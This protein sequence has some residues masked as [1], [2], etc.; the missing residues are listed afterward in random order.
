MATCHGPLLLRTLRRSSAAAAATPAGKKGKSSKAS[1]KAAAAAA[2][3][4]S[5]NPAAAAAAQQVADLARLDEQL[6]LAAFQ[7]AAD[8]FAGLVSKH[9]VKLRLLAALAGLWGLAGPAAV[10]EQYEELAKPHMHVG[11]SELQVRCVRYF[12]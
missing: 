12:C 3:S 10:S 9:D 4:D 11:S 7:E 5:T 1:K 8:L 6:K 2:G